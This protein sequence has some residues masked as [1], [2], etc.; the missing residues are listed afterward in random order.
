[1]RLRRRRG[2]VTG[3]S[4]EATMEATTSPKTGSP[5]QV[6]I[7]GGG[8]AALEAGL[9]LRAYA[10]ERVAVTILTPESEFVYR[11]LAVAAPFRVGESR[12]FPVAEIAAAASAVVRRGWLADVDPEPHVAHTADGATIPYDVL[13][14][15]LGTQPVDAV[16]GALT[17]RGPQDEHALAE[18]LAEARRGKA[19]LAFVVP[20]GVTW[21][22]PLYELALLARWHLFDNY[23]SGARIT[24]AT[25]EDYPLGIFGPEASE[26]IGELL[27]LRGIDLLTGAAPMAFEN[28]VL[29]LVAHEPIEADAVVAL[30]HL[31][32]VQI[33][34]IPVNAQG[35]VDTDASGGVR[36]IDDV[37]A[38]GDMTA[39][40]IK[41]GGLA[42]QQADSA[43]SAI[44]VRAG[45]PMALQPFRPV[46]RGLLLTGGTARYL[47]S[48]AMGRDST[49]DLEP[50]WW[51][52]AKIVGRY[53]AP[54]LAE[55][56]GIEE[57][58]AH[59][60]REIARPIEVEL[61]L[62]DGVV[63]PLA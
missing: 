4:K 59:E 33:P 53:L 44:A 28:G 13:L 43:A 20:A 45:V 36:G 2:R 34:G 42:A 7:A 41:Q 18:I 47:R 54:Y 52:P 8:V 61:E 24:L 1:M 15:A 26:Q 10:E 22:L 27:A 11:P 23:V 19:S 60:V 57:F 48:A 16:P 38:A 58:P 50:L 6:L 25:S 29:H 46:I 56:A 37:Y 35:F 40:P 49:V 62:E 30:P 12:Q 39:F 32:P 14:L 9:A 51:P 31:E 63:K 17:F 55:R 21:P 3:T 5:L